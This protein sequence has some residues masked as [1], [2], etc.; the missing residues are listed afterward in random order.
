MAHSKFA[1]ILCRVAILI[2][3]GGARSALLFLYLLGEVAPLVSPGGV[4]SVVLNPCS[5]STSC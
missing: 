4:C 1:S 2:A 3:S 5:S